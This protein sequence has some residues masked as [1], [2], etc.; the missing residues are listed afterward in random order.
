MSPEINT[1]QEDI[2]ELRNEMRANTE[3]TRKGFETMNGRVKKMEL[4]NAERKGKESVLKG[5][6]L[7][8]KKFAFGL[9]GILTTASA[10][11]LAVAQ[12][13]FT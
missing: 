6:D 10:I 9:L 11:A 4:E 12:G 2:R 7:D 3:L 13:V 8:W 5:S 1:I